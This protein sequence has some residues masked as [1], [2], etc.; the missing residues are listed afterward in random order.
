MIKSLIISLLKST[1]YVIH[2]IPRDLPCQPVVVPKFGKIHYACGRVYLP[3]WLNTDIIANGPENYMYVDLVGRHPFPDNFFRYAFSED[4][5]EHIDQAASLLFLLEAHR[6]LRPGGVLRITTP[7][8]DKVL[9]KHYRQLDF[10]S[11]EIGRNEA[12][13]S[14]GH[15]HFFSRASLC[16]VAQHIGFSVAFVEGGKSSHAELDGLNTRSD[17]VYLHAE[18]TKPA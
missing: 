7:D 12:F 2:R 17:M 18:L 15:V 5:I 10:K 6:T 11:F 4:F 16:T 3:G 13:S 1:G 14:L 9:A 8:L